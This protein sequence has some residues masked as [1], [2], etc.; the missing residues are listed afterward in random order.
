MFWKHKPLNRAENWLLY[1]RSCLFHIHSKTACRG[2]ESF[3]PCQRRCLA[4]SLIGPEFLGIPGFSCVLGWW[5]AVWIAAPRGVYF[6]VFSYLVVS[7]SN[8]SVWHSI[9]KSSKFRG[10]LPC[11]GL[12]WL[13][14][15][16]V[17]DSLQTGRIFLD[18]VHL[19]DLRGA[20]AQEVG[21]L[22][23]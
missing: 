22:A 14:I 16:P 17:R 7:V 4:A 8:L 6:A 3:C 5:D 23:R 10:A 9:N 1:V 11:V 15:E 20:V 19:G 18:V 21:Y 13:E 2:F 12:L